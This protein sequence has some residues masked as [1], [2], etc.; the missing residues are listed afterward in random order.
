MITTE[1]TIERP[2]L[3]SP[4]PNSACVYLLV[5]RLRPD[6]F[7]LGI[8]DEIAVRIASLRGSFGGFDLNASALVGTVNR[9]AALVLEKTMQALFSAP[10]CRATP[11]V[12]SPCS[13]QENAAVIGNGHTEWYQREVFDSMLAVVSELVVRDASFGAVRFS[14]PQRGIPAAWEVRS[15][16]VR[17]VSPEER[18]LRRR[19][20]DE[21]E[22]REALEQSEEAFRRLMAW[23]EARRGRLLS[24][25]HPAEDDRG[26]LR[27][28]FT[29]GLV[30]DGATSGDLH[31]SPVEWDEI[32]PLSWFH[33]HSAT[34]PRFICHNYLE[35]IHLPSDE[36]ATY[37]VGF[38]LDPFFRTVTSG[39]IT[40]PSDLPSRIWAWM[41]GPQA[42]TRP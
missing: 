14:S 13:R 30:S 29:F 33:C 21:R 10:A 31:R 27:R 40:P 15:D 35:E 39:Q 2:A 34:T 38:A 8:T 24:V 23:V 22:A 36:E 37:T 4:T 6:I 17:P 25:S 18:R 11:P 5:S 1:H 3:S 20:R 12:I 7:K 42:M 28:A 9:R 16:A 26:V 32:A 41:V 19:E